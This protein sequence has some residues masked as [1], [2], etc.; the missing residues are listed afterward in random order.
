MKNF[1]QR[2]DVVSLTAPYAVTSGDGMLVGSLFAVAT[3]T[4]ANGAAVE[5]MT[6]GVVRLTALGTDVGALGAKVYWDNTNKR[7]TVTATSN[8]LI[9]CL[10]VAKT[11][12]QTTAVVRLNGTVV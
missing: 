8:T 12:G 2:G 6:Q 4:A 9:G 3:T 5:G 1:I 7:V 11:S 10:T